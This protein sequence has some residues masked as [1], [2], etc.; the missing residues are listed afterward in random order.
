MS[1]HSAA[2]T[3]LSFGA[4]IQY[5][6]LQIQELDPSVLRLPGYQQTDTDPYM[7]LGPGHDAPRRDGVSK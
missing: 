3:Q 6:D 4:G 1:V 5:S 2:T 7:G